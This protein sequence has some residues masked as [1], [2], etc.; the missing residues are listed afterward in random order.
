MP[1]QAVERTASG[2]V[3][4][5]VASP[6]RSLLEAV[7][8]TP[9]CILVGH[10]EQPEHCL[11][12]LGQV[13]ADALVL[14]G[15]GREDEDALLARH[16]RLIYPR[17]AVALIV[18]EMVATALAG[19]ENLGVTVVPR[20]GNPGGAISQ[21]FAPLGEP[22][23][24]LPAARE[25]AA[26]VAL[27]SRRLSGGPPAPGPVQR[28]LTQQVITV[29][30]PK[31]GVGKTL[32]A[33]NLAVAVASRTPARVVLADLDLNSS[34]VG[35]HLDL[36]EGPTLVDVLP[37][38][39]EVGTVDMARFVVTHRPSGLNVLLGPARPE[40]GGLVKMEHLRRILDW[41]RREY[42]F[43]FLDTP[44]DGTSELMQECLQVASRVLLVTTT[45]AASLRQAR[46]AV[47]N[48]RR[49]GVPGDRVILVVNQV[50]DGGPVSLREV[51]GFLGLGTAAALVS[52]RRLADTAV[53]D[54]RPLVLGAQDHPL[55]VSLLSLAG[56][57]C[58]GLIP[59]SPPD[60]R[61]RL[62]GWVRRVLR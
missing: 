45:D 60:S 55:V 50:Y 30:S 17:L 29:C 31:G 9:G 35:V 52:D 19:L 56:M 48:M 3:R 14:A 32:V 46:M 13:A 28:I 16:L 1:R 44:P 4:V 6:D 58:P 54:G 34:D 37:Y 49:L 7:L 15:D 38:L 39:P 26:D 24:G 5:F 2:P 27:P 42:H 41:L 51:Q 23:Q 21:L 20:G 25:M 61:R 10:V 36:L 33:T 11:P 57:V 40:L 22:L 12:I 62:F 43:V 53:F 59:H 47:D 18:P 8:A